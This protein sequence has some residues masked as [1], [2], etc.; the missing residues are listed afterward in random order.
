MI[1]TLSTLLLSLAPQDAPAA[2]PPTEPDI[3]LSI[4]ARADEVRWRQVG[5]VSVRAWSEPDG[6]VIEE[7]LSTGLPRPI[8]G[9]RTFRDVEWRLRGEATI[10]APTP[11]IEV[12]AGP[13]PD[14]PEGDP[15]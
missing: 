3:S 15:E 13:A 9:Q 2:A 12:E 1:A 8:P 5:S 4:T 6:A 7:N 11:Q 10:A 14:T